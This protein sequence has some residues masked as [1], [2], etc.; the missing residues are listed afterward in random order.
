MAEIIKFPGLAYL[1][2]PAPEIL[3]NIADEGPKN[4]FVICWPQDGKMPTYHSNTSD[5]PVILLRLQEFIHKFYNG[6]F[7]TRD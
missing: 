1:P 4:V 2:V 7:Q 5:I 3:R 6:D